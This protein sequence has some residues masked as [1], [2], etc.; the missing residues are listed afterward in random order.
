MST[1]NKPLKYLWT[2]YFE[3]GKVLEQPADDRYSGY[4]EGAEHNFSSFKD[5]TDYEKKAKLIYF[6]INDGSFAYGID[7]AYGVD[8]PSRRF[9]INGTWFSLPEEEPLEDI[10]LEYFRTVKRDDQLMNDGTIVEGEP[11]IEYYNFGYSGKNA[12]GERILKTI[13]IQ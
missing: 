9:G 7:F 11:E 5:L 1:V 12:K 4:V 13:R 6:D 3:D 8:V 2:A 10:R